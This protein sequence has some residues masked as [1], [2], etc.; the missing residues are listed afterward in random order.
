MVT[1]IG[2]YVDTSITRF[3][4]RITLL[5]DFCRLGWMAAVLSV[6]G[7]IFSV[8]YVCASSSQLLIFVLYQCSEIMVGYPMQGADF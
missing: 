4:D 3:T 1:K 5:T 2:G 8:F 6:N 7:V